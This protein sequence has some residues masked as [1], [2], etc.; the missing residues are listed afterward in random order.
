MR[1]PAQRKLTRFYVINPV[2]D[3]RLEQR[4]E[5]REDI[6]VRVPQTGKMFP[7][8]GWDVGQ[9]GMRMESEAILQPNMNIEIVFP[10]TPDQVHCYGRV[11][12]GKPRIGSSIFECGV[13]IEAWHG[14]VKG[15][16]SWSKFKGSRPKS[17]RRVK[18][19]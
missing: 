4:F 1:S 19:R 5:S 8:V 17:E 6:V 13:A 3:R 7:A 14:I 15:G 2:G 16:D 11:V 10:N 9:Y 12:W 18:P